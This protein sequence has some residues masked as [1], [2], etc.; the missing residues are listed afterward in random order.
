MGDATTLAQAEQ[1][2]EKHI[3]F[4][5]TTLL[6]RYEDSYMSETVKSL[7]IVPS[8]ELGLVPWGLLVR[9]S[10]NQRN[11]SS[12]IRLEGV[13]VAPSFRI[14][15]WHQTR[16]KESSQ[17]QV[18]ATV[19]CN[20]ADVVYN[21]AEVDIRLP[22]S[23]IESYYIARSHRTHPILADRTPRKIFET[24]VQ[25]ATILHL[26]AHSNFKKHAPMKS[27]I[28]LFPEGLT[29]N[30]LMELSFKADLV[31]FSSCLSAYARML[32]SGA[33]C[34][35]VHAL[36]ANGSKCFVG[37]LWQ[38][39]DL[40]CAIVML[41]LYINLND[42]TPSAAMY[43]AQSQL[44]NISRDSLNHLCDTIRTLF[45]RDRMEDVKKFVPT[46]DYWINLRLRRLGVSEEKTAQKIDEFDSEF[47][48]SMIPDLGSK[49]DK[50]IDQRLECLR[51]EWCWAAFVV[52]GYGDKRI[53]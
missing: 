51:S 23:R 7:I 37:T 42:M 26:S 8:G 41:Y 17:S 49:F 44:K 14:W 36:L 5:Y 12:G 25:T 29:V 28:D 35:F 21:A 48:G 32:N 43:K 24:E 50:E 6:S 45:K 27:A 11:A 16:S 1:S 53:C 52:I 4:L 10:L 30:N 15:N 31:V 38:V 33:A 18:S 9:Y 2:I 39:P 3:R 19:V 34:G 20:S 13:S 40:A 22:F 46:P 47:D